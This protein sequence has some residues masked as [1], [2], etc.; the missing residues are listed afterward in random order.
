MRMKTCK[1]CDLFDIQYGNSLELI[2]LEKDSNGVNFISRTAKR[3]G[4]SGKVKTLSTEKPFPAGMLTV[5]VG[6][7]ILTTVAILYWLSCYGS[8]SKSRNEYSC[9]TI[10]LPLHKS[11]SL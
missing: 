6:G 10:L 4:V 3:N 8:I 9:K 7:N 2:Y 1:V 5:A 11:Q